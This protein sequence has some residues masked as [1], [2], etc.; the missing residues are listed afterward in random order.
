[1]IFAFD[2]CI[3]APW[4][5][6]SQDRHLSVRLIRRKPNPTG[7]PCATPRGRMQIS[8]CHCGKHSVRVAPIG[9]AK[10]VWPKKRPSR[11]SAK[12]QQGGKDTRQSHVS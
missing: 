6:V 3:D 5:G 11:C 7:N 1:M 4:G 8:F 10:R 9:Q 12:V 2:L